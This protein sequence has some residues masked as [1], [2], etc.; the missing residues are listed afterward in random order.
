MVCDVIIFIFFL[1]KYYIRKYDILFKLFFKLE[2]FLR[3]RYLLGCILYFGI[4]NY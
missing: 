1:V 3:V 4:N 2:L